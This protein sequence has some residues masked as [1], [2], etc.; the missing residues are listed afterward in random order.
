MGDKELEPGNACTHC[1]KGKMRLLVGRVG[2]LQEPGH[3]NIFQCIACGRFEN[4]DIPHQPPGKK[5]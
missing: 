4:R 5:T 3:V 1:G 2:K